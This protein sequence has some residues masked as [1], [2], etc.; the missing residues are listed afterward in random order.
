MTLTRAHTHPNSAQSPDHTPKLAT[1]RTQMHADQPNTKRINAM[2]Q[3][4]RIADSI[5]SC[6][7]SERKEHYRCDVPDPRRDTRDH[8]ASGKSFDEECIRHYAEDVVM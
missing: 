3:Q 7:N 4:V 8:A 2:M 6:A 5:S 1:T